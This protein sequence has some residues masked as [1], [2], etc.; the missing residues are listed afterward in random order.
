MAE[1]IF[2][3]VPHPPFQDRLIPDVQNWAW[4]NIGARQVLGVRWHRMLGTL[5]GT[6]SWFRRG[7]ASTGLTDYGIGCAATDGPG[8]AGLILRWNDPTGAAHPG[9]SP[10]RSPWASG[11]YSSA[12]SF[13]DGRANVDDRGINAVNRD[14]ASLE[15]SG[16]YDTPLDDKCRAA[17]C[18]LTAYFADQDGIPYDEFPHDTAMGY[19]FVKWHT[20]YCGDP[21][22]CTG[23]EKPCPGWV[24]RNET[25]D[26]IA[27]VAS[28][29]EEYQT[30]NGEPPPQPQPPPDENGETDEEET[31]EEKY[32]PDD[33]TPE[34]AARLYD[35]VTI[36]AV[37][38]KYTYNGDIASRHWLQR[39][40]GM[41]PAGKSYQVAPWPQL[42]DVIHRGDGSCVYTWSDGHTYGVP[43]EKLS[44]ACKEAFA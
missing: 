10:N 35:S 32:M 13:G 29:L 18:G 42:T 14:G 21:D 34:L 27:R 30:G 20:E 23:G 25:N 8:A 12:C 41:V 26:L 1:I 3:N 36:N 16:N 5:W 11:P 6:D 4:D 15:L 9:C 40:G 44:S 22:E 31:S 24:V 2:G 39:Y 17:L 28:I 37:T 7:T 43:E 38:I 19:S 33:M